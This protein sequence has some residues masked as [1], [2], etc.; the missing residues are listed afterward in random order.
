M[1]FE[2]R[3]FNGSLFVFE[4]YNALGLCAVGKE[5]RLA[6]SYAPVCDCANRQADEARL[7]EHLRAGDPAAQEHLVRTTAACVAAAARKL[8]KCEEEVRDCVQETYLRAFDKL[9]SFR[10]DSQISTWLTTIARNCALMRLRKRNTEPDPV[11]GLG[12]MQFDEFDFTAFPRTASI[13]CPEKNALDSDRAR[14]LRELIDDLPESYRAI[15]LLRDLEGASTKE[16]AEML[17]L[18]EN[19]VKVRLHRARVALRDRV[20]EV[21]G[22]PG[23][24]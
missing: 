7:I 9:D 5:G 18:T 10:G 22:D 8:L 3:V 15:I 21:F 6:D 12:E 2:P 17:D 23:D 1:E 20:L 4:L 13:P 19:L 24:N 16:T 14:R 11:P